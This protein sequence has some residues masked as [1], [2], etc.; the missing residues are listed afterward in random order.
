MV[1]QN[2]R[3][4]L[5]NSNL[6]NELKNLPETKSLFLPQL[7]AL[8]TFFPDEWN[9]SRFIFS[10]PEYII[11]RLTGNAITVL[12]E[13]RFE[14]AYWNETELVKFNIEKEKLPAEKSNLCLSAGNR[15]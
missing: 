14:S 3:T 15:R 5:W 1:S 8:K 7:A 4:I 10:G 6:K 11:Y 9:G 2:G 13:K 12:P